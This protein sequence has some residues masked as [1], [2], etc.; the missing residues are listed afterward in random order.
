MYVGERE[1]VGV[2]FV[3][4]LDPYSIIMNPRHWFYMSWN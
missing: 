2:W 1:R 4:R 3:G